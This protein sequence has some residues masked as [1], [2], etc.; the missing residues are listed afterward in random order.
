MKY[1]FAYQWRINSLMFSFTCEDID[2]VMETILSA[3]HLKAFGLLAR[4]GLVSANIMAANVEVE[5]IAKINSI[6]FSETE[7]GEEIGRKRQ[8]TI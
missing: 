5:D 1:I 3:N 4:E 2:V 6:F 7:K 8:S